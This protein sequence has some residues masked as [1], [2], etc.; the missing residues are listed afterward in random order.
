[1]ASRRSHAA[2]YSRISYRSPK[3]ILWVRDYG[4]TP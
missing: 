4:E 2:Q 1:M 3:L